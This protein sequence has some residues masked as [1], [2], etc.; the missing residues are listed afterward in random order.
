MSERLLFWCA[1]PLPF[2]LSH[3]T[4]FLQLI[5]NLRDP[6]NPQLRL[7][8]AVGHM[9]PAELVSA[10]PTELAPEEVKQEIKAIEKY[11]AEAS[12]V[13][14]NTEVT[15]RFGS[16]SKCKCPRTSYFMLQTRS[17]DEPMTVFIT[18][19]NCGHAWRK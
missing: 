12:A 1:H 8:V 18:C 17:A 14:K 9:G 11:N 5:R 10:S 15:T 7:R 19:V 6:Q 3:K 13:R 4:K 2:L 16:C